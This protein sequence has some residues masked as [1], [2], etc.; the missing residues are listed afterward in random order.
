[1]K[2]RRLLL[3]DL[4]LSIK[5]ELEKARQEPDQADLDEQARILKSWRQREILN[6]TSKGIQVKIQERRRKLFLDDVPLSIKKN[7]AGPYQR[8]ATVEYPVSQRTDDGVVAAVGDKGPPLEDSKNLSPYKVNGESPKPTG[9]RSQTVIRPDWTP[10]VQPRLRE[11]PVLPRQREAKL[12]QQRVVG[13]ERVLA[14]QPKQPQQRDHNS[15]N[16]TVSAA[17]PYRA[18]REKAEIRPCSNDEIAEAA[19]APPVGDSAARGVRRRIS[20]KRAA[21]PDRPREAPLDPSELDKV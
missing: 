9:R 7:L 10:P 8:T 3:D 14:L 19:A 2:R 18:Q 1:M 4:P 13:P 11:T 6:G 21:T 5:K 16:P 15:H 20:K 12:K 17:D